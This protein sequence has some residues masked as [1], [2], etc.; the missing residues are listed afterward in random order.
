M[1]KLD[2]IERPIEESEARLARYLTYGAVAS[3]VAQRAAQDDYAGLRKDREIAETVPRAWRQLL[4][5][6]DELLVDLLAD[7]VETLCGFKP[8][9][10]VVARFLAGEAGAFAG[11]TGPCVAHGTI[12]GTIRAASPS[13]PRSACQ[14]PTRHRPRVPRRR[15]TR[16]QRRTR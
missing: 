4:E 6:Q 2:L 1:Y 5:D 8:D 14:R 15:S 16:G 10:D 3:G 11:T 9:P 13:R 12:T 7:Q